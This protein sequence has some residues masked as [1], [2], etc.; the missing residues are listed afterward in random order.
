MLLIG[1]FQIHRAH[2]FYM[3][4][5]PCPYLGIFGWLAGAAAIALTTQNVPAKAIVALLRRVRPAS[6]TRHADRLLPQEGHN[7]KQTNLQLGLVHIKA[8]YVSRVSVRV[9]CSDFNFSYLWPCTRGR[10]VEYSNESLSLFKPPQ[11]LTSLQ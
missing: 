8:K 7:Q 2:R 4:P 9:P 1:S 5:V 6:H 11:T 3:D 10:L